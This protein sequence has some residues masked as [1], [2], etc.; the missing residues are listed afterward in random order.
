MLDYSGQA[1]RFDWRLPLLAGVEILSTLIAAALILVLIMDA[2][3]DALGSILG[4]PTFLA[5]FFA[6]GS[7][8]ARL[9]LKQPQTW[10]RA[11]VRLAGV[12]LVVLAGSATA[13]FFVGGGTHY[14]Q[15]LHNIQDAQKRFLK[16][17][18][19]GFDDAM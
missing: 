17:H 1:K 6:M 12:W 14:L 3:I 10:R 16:E 8:I 2:P 4:G 9:R 7:G 18:P 19:S 13:A 15:N 11:S 5:I